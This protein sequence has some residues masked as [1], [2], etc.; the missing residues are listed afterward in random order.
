MM[1]KK[2]YEILAAALNKSYLAT[3]TVDQHVV[4]RVVEDLAV[5][6]NLQNTR[7]DVVA[8]VNRVLQEKPDVPLS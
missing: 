3:P 2:D 6:L 5:A 7:F 1:S 4:E 8:F